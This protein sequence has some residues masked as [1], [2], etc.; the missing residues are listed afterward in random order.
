MN[1]ITDFFS[2]AHAALVSQSGYN[3]KGKHYSEY[4]DLNSFARMYILHEYTAN[5]DGGL[6]STFF[7]KLPQDDKLYAVTPWDF[8]FALFSATTQHRFG[9][10]YSSPYGWVTALSSIPAASAFSGKPIPTLFRSAMGHEEFRDLVAELWEELAPLTEKI[11]EEELPRMAEENRASAVMDAYRW[12][13]SY[14]NSEDRT[15]RKLQGYI[16]IKPDDYAAQADAYLRVTEHMADKC[17][18]RVEELNVGLSKD[19]ALVFLSGREGE[20]Y[21]VPEPMQ[22]LGSELSVPKYSYKGTRI[23]RWNTSPDLSGAFYNFEDSMLL[24][25]RTTVLYAD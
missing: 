8:D 16:A 22:K 4:F 10:D 1:Y 5:A 19:A 7:L 3:E 2:E 6:A 15:F 11:L 9:I 13:I 12:G 18:I 20:A 14:V 23:Y 21:T 17:R 24:T 25:E